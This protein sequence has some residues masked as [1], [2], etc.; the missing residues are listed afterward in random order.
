[1]PTS[2]F[3]T[4]S[5]CGNGLLEPGEQCDCA[6]APPSSECNSDCCNNK[7]CQLVGAAQCAFGRC[8]DVSVC[9]VRQSFL[10]TNKTN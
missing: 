10:K 9:A 7:T 8:C 6:R 1:M 2:V 5:V 4:A 3:D